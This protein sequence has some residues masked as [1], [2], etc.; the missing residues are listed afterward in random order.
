M[1]RKLMFNILVGVQVLLLIGLVFS[2][3]LVERYGQ[4]I[5]LL[6]KPEE[7]RYLKESNHVYLDFVAE[8]IRPENWFM[9]D[10]PKGNQLIYVLL[11][12]NEQGVYQVKAASD[13]RMDTSDSE[14]IMRARYVYQDHLTNHHNVRFGLERYNIQ[15]EDL[16]LD[17]G[18]QRFRVTVATSPWGQTK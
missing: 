11:T 15:H 9:R 18:E 1:N 7:T 13:K 3:Y 5:V 10:E 2:G 16:E 14:V 4:E 12:P 6:T 17:Q 8:E